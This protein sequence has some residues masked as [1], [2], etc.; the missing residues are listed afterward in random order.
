MSYAI[1]HI[2][3]FP[4]HIDDDVV[5]MFA[6][7]RTQN[8]HN[9]CMKCKKNE[10]FDG[11]PFCETC[12]VITHAQRCCKICNI[13]YTKYDDG[14]CFVCSARRVQILKRR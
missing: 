6:T 2:D 12:C 8:R 13:R 14:I 4:E 5:N 1:L 7:N 10:T 9:K 3:F 11:Y